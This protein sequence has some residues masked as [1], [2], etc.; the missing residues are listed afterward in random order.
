MERSFIH[1]VRLPPYRTLTN[2]NVLHSNPGESRLIQVIVKSQQLTVRDK[3]KGFEEQQVS[4][5][6][7]GCLLKFVLVSAE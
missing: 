3:Q 1:Q 4:G 5:L 6:S 2:T 7:G